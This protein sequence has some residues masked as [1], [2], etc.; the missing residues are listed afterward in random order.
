[1]KHNMKHKMS[2]KNNSKRN[3]KKRRNNKKSNKRKYYIS[4]KFGGTGVLLNQEPRAAFEYFI[5]NSTFKIKSY[6]SNGITI[7]ATL[8]PTIV[9]PYKSMDSNTY[10][11][12]INRIIIKLILI[13]AIPETLEITGGGTIKSTILN[14][15]VDELNIQTDIALKTMNYL[16]P[17]CPSPLYF[18]EN[19]SVELLTIILDNIADANPKKITI[20]HKVIEDMI[21][22]ITT[23]TIK[24]ISVIG[25]EFAEN[26]VELQSVLNKSHFYMAVYIII[27]LAIDTGYHHGDY[28]GSNVMINTTK[29]NYFN[30]LTGAPLLI[31]F[32]LAVKIQPTIMNAIK[33]HYK[34]KT[35]TEILFI[36]SKIPRKDGLDLR[37]YPSHYGYMFGQKYDNRTRQTVYE[38]FESDANAKIANLFRL[39]E[40]SIQNTIVSLEG[41]HSGNPEV[42]LLPLSKQ[43]RTKMYSGTDI[44]N[45]IIVS[46]FGFS[47]L[48]T[49]MIKLTIDW[50]YDVFDKKFKQKYTS[51]QRD[52]FF[53]MFCYNFIYI[54]NNVSFERG[55]IQ[56]YS[57]IALLFIENFDIE[58][59][60]MDET[61][62]DFMRYI[63]G[64]ANTKEQIKLKVDLI[65]PLF[66]NKNPNSQYAHM[67]ASRTF[68]TKDELVN[69]MLQPIVYSDP[70]SLLQT[71]RFIGPIQ[72]IIQTDDE[73]YVFPDV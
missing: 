32:G 73:A 12:P 58:D 56:A 59:N 15:V 40:E 33:T 71:E 3:T 63:S 5:N 61:A 66:I 25:M 44:T 48:E 21:D 23:N 68:A 72:R 4:Y 6:G 18:N 45:E 49:R 30:G 62:I 13:N 9:S 34:N 54:L 22:L 8:K 43:F 27:K 64:N 57:L 2:K 42:P 19:I 69:F 39:R 29:T 17:L 41:L 70:A 24:S 7:L 16:E 50:I 65:Y 14:N 36:L 47:E 1:M 51:S 55:F 26:C 67:F 35:Y 20:L 11:T 37:S 38:G 31:D 52:C 46:N 28:H 10:G 60:N 53:I